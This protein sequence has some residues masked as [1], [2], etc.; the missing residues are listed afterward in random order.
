MLHFAKAGADEGMHRF[1]SAFHARTRDILGGGEGAA[2]DDG[3]SGGHE[4]VPWTKPED[5]A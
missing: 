3:A 2:E 5:K 1:E 4:G